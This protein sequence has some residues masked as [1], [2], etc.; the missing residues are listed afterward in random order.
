MSKMSRLLR[1]ELN[2]ILMRPIL[3]VITGVLVLALIFSV[4]LFNQENRGTYE[5]SIAGTTKTDAMTNFISAQNMNKTVAD[6]KVSDAYSQLEYYKNLSQ[7][8]NTIVD[9]LRLLIGEGSAST[10]GVHRLFINYG[11]SLQDLEA[12]IEESGQNIENAAATAALINTRQNMINRLNDAKNLIS[13]NI[14]SNSPTILM[15]TK[16]F[17][18]YINLISDAL[19]YL[20]AEGADINLAS[21]HFNIYNQISSVSGFSDIAGVTYIDKI[22]TLTVGAIT[23]IVLEE[24]TITNLDERYAEVTVFMAQTLDNINSFNTDEEVTLAQLK[25]EMLKYYYSADQ[26]YALVTNSIYYEPVKNFNDSQ[27]HNYFGY[28]SVYLYEIKENITANDFLIS[29][30]LT[31]NEYSAVFSP[32]MS[33]GDEVSAFDLVYFGME[34][35][36]FIILIFC[37]VLAAGMIAGEQSGG[38]LKVLAIRPFSRNKILTSK[39]LAS[40]IFG[41]I[42][43]IFSAIVLFIIGIAL[44]GLDM[45]PILAIFNASSAFLISPI[46]L[47]L[48]YLALMIVKILFYVLLATMISSVFRSNVGAVVISIFI[49]FL[50][51]LFAVLFTSSTWYALLPFAGI[52]FFKFFGG[53]FASDLANPL[54]IAFSSPMFYNSNLLVSAVIVTATMII[55]T[56]LSYVVFKKREIK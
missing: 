30:N 50:T 39:I 18:N 54:S 44:Y 25:D 5:Y 35:C 53:A 43:L 26:F 17:E 16:D 24:S 7:E 3:Y 11:A 33:S 10:P 13:Q 1:G 51:A 2:K 41:V 6:G 40:L 8:T 49:Y 14:Q 28:E 56:V 42:F 23:P 22:Y 27:A 37:V 12:D 45:T 15:Q 47:I 19:F 29:N 36:S 31:S 55:M 32:T 20:T 34:I 48:I 52:D 38:T 21:T 4:T 9:E 46:L